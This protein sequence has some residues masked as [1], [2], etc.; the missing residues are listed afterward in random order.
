M[1]HQYFAA[2]FVFLA[3]IVAPEKL[4]IYLS[5][6]LVTLKCTQRKYT[7]IRLV[8]WSAILQALGREYHQIHVK[9]GYL[10]YLLRLLKKN[11]LKSIIWQKTQ[12]TVRLYWH[13][14]THHPHGELV[15]IK[16]N[17]V[18]RKSVWLGVI[19]SNLADAIF[20]TLLHSRCSLC[21]TQ[22]HNIKTAA[23][24]KFVK[25]GNPHEIE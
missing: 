6:D 11:P 18:K 2:I 7:G 16:Y 21:A 19:T 4:T 3:H 12:Q 25:I 20:L 9:S 24:I 22:K 17:F 5:L 13:M 1:Y 14:I 10:Q 15:K 23:E 8:E